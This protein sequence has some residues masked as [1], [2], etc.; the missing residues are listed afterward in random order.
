MA[1]NAAIGRQG[2]SIA[3]RHLERLGYEIR[4][5][6]FRCAE[7]EIDLV[8]RKDE[9][10]VFI[11]VKTRSM[12]TPYHPTLAVTAEKR[13][14]LRRL[15]EYYCAN[16]LEQPLQPRFDVVAVV[17]RP[18]VPRPKRGQQFHEALEHFVNAF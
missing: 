18:I 17:L 15:G 11:E 3:A 12:E 16:Y 2:E 6:N 13:S 1:D 9:Y 5:R 4:E 8:A 14:R 7:G 10:V